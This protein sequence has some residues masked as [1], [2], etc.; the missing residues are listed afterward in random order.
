ML[1]NIRQVAHAS[2]TIPDECPPDFLGHRQ[3]L[4]EY[5]A[6]S[7]DQLKVSSLRMRRTAGLQYVLPISWVAARG[8]R[9]TGSP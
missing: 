8:V 6:A 4:S 9:L 3:R 2:T 5:L 1:P 7:T